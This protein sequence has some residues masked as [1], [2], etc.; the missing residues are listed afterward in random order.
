MNFV[1]DIRM[2]QGV[3]TMTDNSNID[4]LTGL[5]N[6]KGL[7]EYFEASHE[8]DFVNFMFLDL[9]NFKA[10]NDIYGHQ[11]GDQ[12]LSAFGQILRDCVPGAVAVRIGG[13]EFVLL[14]WGKLEREELA[15]IAEKIK[16][17][18]KEKQRELQYLTIISVSIGIVWNST[19]TENIEQVLA[20]SDTAMYQAK[21]NGKNGYM[22]YNDMEGKILLEKSMEDTAAAALQ[23]EKFQIRYIPVINMQNSSLV[24]TEI[25][26]YWQKEDGTY[27][28][29]E[30]YRPVLDRNGFIRKLDLYIFEQ[31]CRQLQVFHKE[32]K[33]RMKV[34]MELS[35]LLFLDD[36]IPEYLASLMWRYGVEAKDIDLGLD[37]VALGNRDCQK[38]IENM[39]RL[40]N[41][42]FSL[43]LVHFGRDF[44]S[45]RYLGQLPVHTI[46]F[47]KGYLT[48]NIQDHRSRKIIR[49]LVKMGKDLKM[50][51]VAQGIAQKKDIIFLSG[52]GCDAAAGE[53]YMEPMLPKKYVYYAK[54]K[55]DAADQCIQYPFKADLNTDGGRLGGMMQ[56]EGIEFVDGISENWGGI[57]FSGGDVGKNVIYFPE[58]LFS[59]NSYTVSLWIKMDDVTNWGSVLYM[60]YL[61]G[62]SSLVPNIGD[63]VSAYRISEDSY[64]NVW[65]DILCRAVNL[66]QWSMLTISYDAFSETARYYI[67]GRKAGYRINV[68]TLLSCRQVIL[69]GDPFQRSFTGS[70]SAFMIYDA[71]K[72]DEE[73]EK[74]YR[75]FVDEPGFCGI[76]EDYWLDSEPVYE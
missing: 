33:F 34:R 71:V 44:S 6:R 55:V 43:S 72:T 37:E 30:E 42:G 61:E 15:G 24:Q 54:Q 64:V 62:F 22:F 8:K 9:D 47:D 3:D 41:M 50:T 74:L 12:V 63:G 26:V 69:G 18:V 21:Q 10:V 49:I 32:Y 66:H 38:I 46:Q 52:C 16:K 73:V 48:E 70:V 68:P 60:R 35:R 39:N 7:Y 29:P 56:G 25:T 40:V 65:H 19:E 45:F 5:Y 27:W 53:Y 2:I 57:H 51:M 75:S 14:L 13:D 76:V 23:E 58:Q 31:L 4:Y 28:K 1:R 36:N 20:N 11:A 59:T 17:D 67:N